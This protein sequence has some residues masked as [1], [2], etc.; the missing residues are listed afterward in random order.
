MNPLMATP[1]FVIQ[2]KDYVVISV[3]PAKTSYTK[4]QLRE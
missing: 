3:S 4:M 2:I 1:K